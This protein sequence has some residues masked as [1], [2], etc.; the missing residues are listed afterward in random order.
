MRR[1]AATLLVTAALL[2]A[3]FAANAVTPGEAT[4]AQCVETIVRGVFQTP[5]G[6]SAPEG[7][8]SV[9]EKFSDLPESAYTRNLLAVA[10]ESGVIEGYPDGTLRPDEPVERAEFA[11]MLYRAKALLQTEPAHILP[12]CKAYADVED[13]FET[14]AAWC[15]ETGLMIGY[16]DAFGAHDHLTNEQLDIVFRRFLLGLSTR[17]K[18]AALAVAGLPEVDFALIESTKTVDLLDAV[19]RANVSQGSPQFRP[20]TAEEMRKILTPLERIANVDHETVTK[21]KILYGVSG[22]IAFSVAGL[23]DGVTDDPTAY[24]KA[25]HVK[26]ESLF[27]FS[28]NN[29]YYIPAMGTQKLCG[30]EFFKYISCDEEALPEGV[31]I[32]K[33]YAC[34]ATVTAVTTPTSGTRYS[35]TR[36]A[37]FETF[38]AA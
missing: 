33:W 38:T 25:H 36:G 23:T 34:T 35:F 1:L 22:K 4:R 32:G 24:S 15:F 19:S 6:T 27:A 5:F 20:L 3:A 2:T 9:L 16:G 30:Y 14:E 29:T 11:C 18:Y 31:E 7:D 8:T 37:P 17:D 10:V 12:P 13:W 28:E 26:R 21:E